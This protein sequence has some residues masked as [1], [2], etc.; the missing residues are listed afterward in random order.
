MRKLPQN[1]SLLAVS[2]FTVGAVAIAP[3]SAERGSDS[4]STTTTTQTT[5][6]SSSGSG[7]SA[8]GIAS[9]APEN[10]MPATTVSHETGTEGAD[11]TA[12]VTPDSLR[13]KAQ[14]LLAAD[15][16]GKQARPLQ[17]RQQACDAHKAE[18][19]TRQ[20]NYAASGQ[21]HL[22]VFNSIYAKVVA[23]QTKNQL[24]AS[25]YDSL[26][27]TAD[28]KQAA[29]QAAVTALGSQSI[30]IDCTSTDP[31]ANVATLKTAV[32]TARQA[33]Q[34]YR[35][36]IKNVVVALQTAKDSTASTGSN[37]GGAQ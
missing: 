2:I 11:D 30:T 18:L 33:L 16:K 3:V 29:A 17:V 22:D 37:T 25:N 12:K 36:A 7:S 26:K 1:L 4:S 27:A 10:G 35:T 13:Q 20:Q 24:S 5:D 9:R 6:G 8:S 19:T 28:A 21:K 15:R 14:Q 32:A 23:F 31:A 34:D